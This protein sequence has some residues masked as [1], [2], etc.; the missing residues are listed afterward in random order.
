MAIKRN[1]GFLCY[2]SFD[3]GNV[4]VCFGPN[5]SIMGLFSRPVY[6]TGLALGPLKQTKIP[7]TV[8]LILAQANILCNMEVYL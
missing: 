3:L 4:Q 7:L 5:Y 6:H 1:D 2:I 8:S